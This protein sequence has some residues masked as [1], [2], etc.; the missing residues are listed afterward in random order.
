MSARS[1]LREA[2][3]SKNLLFL[4]Y[5][6]DD[7]TVSVISLVERGH[8]DVGSMCH[9]K[10][11]KKVYKGVIMS[12]G[13]ILIQQLPCTPQPHSLVV[14]PPPSYPLVNP[15]PHSSVVTP[16][17]PHRVVTPPAPPLVT[18]PRAAPVTPP[19]PYQVVTPPVPQ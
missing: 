7:N 3:A 13:K 14:T 4:V 5:F 6:Q 18:T 19:P 10:E 12:Y 16:P 1:Y 9:V 15:P 2:E 8:L 17:P 11:K